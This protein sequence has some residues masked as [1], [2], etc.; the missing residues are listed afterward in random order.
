[1]EKVKGDIKHHE[2]LL[3]ESLHIEEDPSGLK[4]R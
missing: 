3:K 4:D 2:F 1:M